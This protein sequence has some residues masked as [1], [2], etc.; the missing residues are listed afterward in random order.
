M[1]YGYDAAGRNISILSGQTATQAHDGDGQVVKRIYFDDYSA[2]WMTGCYLHSSVM[3]GSVIAEITPAGQRRR[4]YVHLG[5]EVLAKQEGNTVNWRHENPLTGSRGSSGTTGQYAVEAEFD[6]TGVNIGFSD[7][8][9]DPNAGETIRRRTD[10]SASSP[11]TRAAGV[12]STALPC[13]ARW[14]SA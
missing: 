2:T 4:R 13:P 10:S 8:Y 5:A 9:V 7:P 12:A 1:S 3:G 11:M 14:S 6:P